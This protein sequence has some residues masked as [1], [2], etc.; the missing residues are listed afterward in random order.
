MARKCSSRKSSRKGSRKTS[1]KGS[2][3]SGRKA[4]AALTRTLKPDEVLIAVVGS[5][6][7]SRAQFVKHIWLFIKK[8]KL[9]DPNDGRSILAHKHSCLRKLL[10]KDKA[11]LGDVA[12]A[13]SK[14]TS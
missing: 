14:H 8:N 5:G 4:P 10:G 1:R 11:G 7:K 9:Q 6:S 12:K 13:I 2:R 3:K